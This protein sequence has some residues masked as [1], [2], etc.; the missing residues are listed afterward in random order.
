MLKCLCVI[1]FIVG[2]W[3]QIDTQSSRPTFI[4]SFRRLFKTNCV[5]N[6]R[7][8]CP[9][10]HPSVP[11]RSDI[12]GGVLEGMLM[13]GWPCCCWWQLFRA[14][15]PRPL[16]ICT[17]DDWRMECGVTQLFLEGATWNTPT[18]D[19]LRINSS[20]CQTVLSGQLELAHCC[21]R[22]TLL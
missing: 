6:V 13:L 7:H 11:C 5:I 10:V 9:P 19:S 2:V 21:E 12:R 4:S 16:F 1:L 18:G 15:R 14:P 3:G 17:P 20:S 22:Q 8:T